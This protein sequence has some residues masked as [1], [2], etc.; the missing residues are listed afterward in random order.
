M[1][2]A[3]GSSDPGTVPPRGG[4][5]NGR[6]LHR[7]ARIEDAVHARIE[8]RVSEKGWV[9][10]VTAY[11]GYGT[12]GW[13]RV[14]ARV[15][16][17]RPDPRTDRPSELVRGWRSFVT[18]PRVGTEVVL[19]AG[20]TEQHVT[21]DRGGFVDVRFECE[22]DVGWSNVTVSTEGADDVRAPILVVD[23]EA[24]TGLVS[25]VDDTV[26]VTTLPRAVLAAWNTFVLN[27][28]ARRPVPGMAVLYERWT[29]ANPTAPV[30]YLS[31]GAWNV[32]PTLHRFL[33]RHLYPRGPLLLTDWGPTRDGWFRSGRTHKRA[34]LERLASEFPSIRWLLVGDDGQ[35]D[36]DIY[37]EF[38]SSH[39][40]SVAAVAI[41]H[42]SPTE[43]V[44]ASGLP[45]PMDQAKSVP[46][47]PWIT[48]TDGAALSERLGQAGLL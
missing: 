44:L 31:T 37:S 6:S 43:Q 11:T 41:R 15:L 29:Q 32:A 12:P 8:R 17:T 3:V 2:G 38:A 48:G 14:M 47:T 33:S 30:I 13:A 25:D 10:A 7:A 35:H 42:L 36:P 16:M 1:T 23:P 28:H 40:D 26:M 45:V 39:H 22:L 27:E 34:S 5:S 21:T 24:G 20:E 19:R 4:F 9:P 46:G 18:V